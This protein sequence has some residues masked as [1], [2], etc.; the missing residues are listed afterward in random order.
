MKLTPQIAMPLFAALATDTGWFRFASTSGETYRFGGQL[1]DAGASPA[2]IY[3]AIYEQDTSRRVQLRG[4][5]LA[6]AQTELD[7]RLA[8]HL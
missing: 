8:L 3:N 5:V 7:G 2:A 6:R 4:R 1:V